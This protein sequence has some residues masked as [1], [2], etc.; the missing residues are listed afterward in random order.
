MPT[1][2]RLPV[3][4]DSIES[5]KVVSWLVQPGDKV[6]A[7]Q[8]VAEV[9]T[10]KATIEIEAPAAG[11]LGTVH[12]I[13]GT[14]AV[15]IGTVLA[16]ILNDAEPEISGRAVVAD[17]SEA[18]EPTIRKTTTQTVTPLAARMVKLAALDLAD[19]TPSQEGRI[20]KFEVQ[21]ALVARQPAASSAAPAQLAVPELQTADIS[22]HFG[23]HPFT[24][25]S[26]TAMRRV[27]AARL[28][29]AKQTIPHFYLGT[30]CR[31][32]D[33]IALRAQ[34]NAATPSAKL[35]ITD[36]VIAAT[37]QALRNVPAANSEWVNG[38]VRMYENVDIAVAVNTDRGLIT[39]IIRNCNQKSLRT[40][41]AEVKQLSARAR[42]GRLAPNEYTG[43]TFTISNL[44]MF[45][46]T[47]ITP[48]INLPQS[49]ILGVGS[50]EERP[51]VIDGQ[52]A[53]GHMMSCTLAADHRAI[54]GAIGAGLLAHIRRA[55]ENPLTITLDP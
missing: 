12:V 2:I 15:P 47:S 9:E 29:E 14:D 18:E 54:D 30:D 22:N 32:D 1:E 49:C 39:P 27:T 46:V 40:I 25:Q 38:A 3:L 6:S 10:D 44:G 41:S 35:T 42:Q 48:I 11:V 52:V 53:P 24:D 19:V 31:V 8:P 45:H 20:T 13:A 7:G 17:T 33:L 16:V 23:A 26:P 34:L 43:G 36:F 28:Q 51:V 50:I 4:A 55:L 21:Q 5:A 37:A